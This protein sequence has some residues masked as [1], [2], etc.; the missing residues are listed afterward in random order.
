MKQAIKDIFQNPETS[1]EGK[2]GHKKAVY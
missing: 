1:E 2:E